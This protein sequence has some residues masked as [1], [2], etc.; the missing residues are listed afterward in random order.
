MS[1]MITLGK[2]IPKKKSVLLFS[3]GMDSL[4]M[5]YLLKPDILLVL[6]HGNKYEE[7]E[8]RHISDLC[9]KWGIH[10]TI[11][12][13]SLQLGEFERDDAIIPN[14]NLY[15]ITLA[16]HY[17]ETIWLGSVYGDRSLDKSA[18]FFKK[19]EDIFNYLFQEQHWCEGRTFSI[20]APYKDK[21]KTELVELFLKE[22]GNP[23]MLLDSYSCY[24]GGEKP[25][26]ICKPCFRK[27]VSLKNNGIEMKDYFARDPKSAPWLL[28][29]LPTILKNEYRGREDNDIKRALEIA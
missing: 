23:Q 27:W 12:D 4:M 9:Q 17:G 24:E 7:Q 10:R 1:N 14:R 13:G 15:F 6:P 19:C 2:D 28:K 3:G 20:S 11:I 22:G 5:D 26:G 21:T 16:T 29:L 8:M 25:C 18:E